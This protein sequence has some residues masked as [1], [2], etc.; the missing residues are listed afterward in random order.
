M[1]S[2]APSLTLSPDGSDIAVPSF[3]AMSLN[4]VAQAHFPIIKGDQAD[5]E[6]DLFALPMSPRSP[7]MKRSHFG[8]F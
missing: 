3:A 8:V 1:G 7:D 6:D 2:N 4:A 5:T